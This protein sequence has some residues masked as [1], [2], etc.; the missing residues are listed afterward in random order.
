L[1][2]EL[3]K[4]GCHKCCSTSV[5]Q[6]PTLISPAKN[7]TTSNSSVTFN[8]QANDWGYNLNCI[9]SFLP[10]HNLQVSATTNFS[11]TLAVNINFPVAVA[12]NVTKVGTNIEITGTYFPPVGTSVNVTLNYHRSVTPYHTPTALALQ[13]PTNPYVTIDCNGDDIQENLRGVLVP[14]SV[15]PGFDPESSFNR[16]QIDAFVGHGSCSVVMPHGT[17]DVL[18]GQP[19]VGPVWEDLLTGGTGKS[20]A[21]IT[22]YP[23]ATYT[24]NRTIQAGRVIRI[25]VSAVPNLSALNINNLTTSAVL[26]NF[27]KLMS[28]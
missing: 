7:S 25:P 12:T 22:Y 8:W 18:V 6:A 10:R 16:G 14:L 11:G 3:P 9:E 2:C 4:V 24:S 28:A 13:T 19:P 20:T 15:L 21:T 1:Q 23:E 5:P 26:L 17:N 27:D